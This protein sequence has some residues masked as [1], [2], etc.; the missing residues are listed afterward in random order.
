MHPS[1]EW[2]K[3]PQFVDSFLFFQLIS[4]VV[5]SDWVSL[6][7]N[8]DIRCWKEMLAA[9]LTYAKPEDFPQLCGNSFLCLCPPILFGWGY[10]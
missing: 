8:C 6:I 1:C 2:R 10:V 7:K 9:I 3:H 5:T 4:A